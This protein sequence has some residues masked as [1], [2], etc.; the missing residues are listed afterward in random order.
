MKKLLLTL[1]TAAVL[2]A[3]YTPGA[4][5][6]DEN[7]PATA[8]SEKPKRDTFPFHGK[9]GEVDVKGMTFTIPGKANTRHFAITATTKVTKG[10]KPAKLSDAVQGEPV[11]GLAK[12]IKEGHYEAVSVRFGAKPK[13]RR[14]VLSSNNNQ[15]VSTHRWHGLFVRTYNDHIEKNYPEPTRAFSRH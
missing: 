10:G 9:V 15:A 1:L 14:N 2:T 5:M 3:G 11:G 8:Q 13:S 6:A 12:K 7:K 4:A